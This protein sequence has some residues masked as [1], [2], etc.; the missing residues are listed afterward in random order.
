MII[1]SPGEILLTA[2]YQ[3]EAPKLPFQ[4]LMRC[5]FWS[6]CR[7]LKLKGRWTE[8]HTDELI[9]PPSRIGHHRTQ[10][11]REELIIAAPDVVSNE[12]S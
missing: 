6:E 3:I 12:H 1:Y 10:M 5:S 9:L 4:E 8:R 11:A 7:L 2:T